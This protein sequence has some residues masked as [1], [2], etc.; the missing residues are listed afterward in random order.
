M[1][2]VP[3][4]CNGILLGNLAICW[5]F[6]LCGI[7]GECKTVEINLSF[8]ELQLF[9]HTPVSAENRYPLSAKPKKGC[10]PV[11]YKEAENGAAKE[12]KWKL[13]I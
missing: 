8:L 3:A 12:W 1:V 7:L 10:L 2:H 5:A 6:Q 13:N 11:F 9:Y 4:T